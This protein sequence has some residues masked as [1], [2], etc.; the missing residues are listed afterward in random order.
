MAAGIGGVMGGAGLLSST[1]LAVR[2]AE[3]IGNMEGNSVSRSGS[4]SGNAGIMGDYQPFIIVTRPISDKPSTFNNNLGQTYNKS[5]RIGDLSG[6]T[7]VEEAHIEGMT[8]TDAEKQEIERLLK[9]G[10][11]V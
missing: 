8:A 1:S 11:I 5:A 2:G 3:S 7:I 4:I 6:F 9:E 10:V